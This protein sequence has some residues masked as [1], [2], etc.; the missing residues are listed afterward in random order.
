MT[1]TIEE[2]LDHKMDCP[3]C[4]NIR[5]AL[6]KYFAHTWDKIDM[7]VDTRAAGEFCNLTD[8]ILIAIG[9]WTEE[10]GKTSQCSPSRLG[11]LI[12]QKIEYAVNENKDF[13]AGLN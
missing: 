2:H 3:E 6:L 5:K 1:D 8:V 12:S 13:I 9:E 10:A 11:Y 7:P 4:E